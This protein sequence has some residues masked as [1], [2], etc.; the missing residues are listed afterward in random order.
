MEGPTLSN[1]TDGS[2]GSPPC[3]E[4]PTADA[5][6]INKVFLLDVSIS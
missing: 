5:R 6:R 2:S 1:D 3:T 4:D